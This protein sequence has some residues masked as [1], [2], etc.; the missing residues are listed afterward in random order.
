MGPRI[1]PLARKQY[2]VDTTPVKSIDAI[3]TLIEGLPVKT[4]AIRKGYCLSEIKPRRR[5]LAQLKM[6]KRH[7][8][9]CQKGKR[10]FVSDETVILPSAKAPAQ[11]ASCDRY[12]FGL[13]E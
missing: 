12:P 13:A 2:A 5:S 7:E 11:K 9:R 1:V 3:Q 10:R 4:M 6:D 8:E